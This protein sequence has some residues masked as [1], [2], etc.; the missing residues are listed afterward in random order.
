M[1]DPAVPAIIA[2]SAGS[3]LVAAIG[4]RRRRQAEAVRASR[5]RLGLR[6]P[7]SLDPLRAYA[8]VSAMSGLP[9]TSELVAEGAARQGAIEHFL[10]V[11]S[12]LRGSVESSLRGVI[13]SLRITDAPP[14][15]DESV[16]LALRLFA[17]T[18]I[19]LAT[20]N[21][22]EASRALLSGMTRLH[23][24]EQIILRLAM[25]PGSPR[26]RRVSEPQ[27]RAVRELERAWR[28]K[29][30]SGGCFVAGLV[31]VRAARI[32]RAR[33]LAAHIESVI[34]SRRG[35]PREV[36]ITV[37]RGNRR[38]SAMPRTTRSSGWLGIAELLL[39]LGWPL[40]PELVPGVEA[41]GARG[42]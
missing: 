25:R 23:A 2:A 34:R 13:G 11:P 28:R 22:V 27:S 6:F 3:G 29:T 15:S 8:A 37:G 17:T 24:G 20:E 5:Q 39:L 16:T 30:T 35:M 12:S 19:L 9:Y 7:I 32:G 10:W 26:A 18:P 1:N 41:G 31:L 42:G 21:V 33:E 36:R 14:S 4:V 40:G 38:M